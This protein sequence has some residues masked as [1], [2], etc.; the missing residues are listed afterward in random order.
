[1]TNAGLLR[2]F[3]AILYDSLLVVA[4]MF[5]ATTPFIAI[6]G[7]EFVEPGTLVYQLAL[8]AVA[9]LFFVGFWSRKGRTL[10]MQSWSLQL[11]DRD[12]RI[13]GPGACTLRFFAAMLSWIPVG[14][15]FFWQWIDRDRLTWHDRLSGTRI[16][17]IP[18]R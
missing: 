12:G 7:G 11:V 9:G 13:P 10:G 15:G 1:M 14:L 17:H 2:R 6:R 3:A 16:V 8:L 18:R 5:L 4:L